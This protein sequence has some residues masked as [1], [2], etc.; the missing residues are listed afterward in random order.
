MSH[1]FDGRW[2]YLREKFPNY[3]DNNV[4]CGMDLL[5]L[6][7]TLRPAVSCLLHCHLAAEVRMHQIRA[8]EVT[9]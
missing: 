2:C 6:T 9:F 4:G 5:E 3:C 1:M 8:N 7:F